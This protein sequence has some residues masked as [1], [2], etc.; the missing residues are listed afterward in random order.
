LSSYLYAGVAAQV[1]T[2]L[3]PYDQARS[4]GYADSALRAMEWAEAQPTEPR[5]ADLVVSHRSVAAAAMLKL[6]GDQR[7]HDA[8][9]EATTLDDGVDPNLSCHEHGR[10]DAAW[11]YLGIDESQT[12]PALR[13]TIEQSF[14][15]TAE[16]ILAAAAE[17]SFGWAVENPFV[18]LIWG[19]GVGGSPSSVGLLRAYELTGDER[20]RDGALRSAAVSLGANPLNTAFVTGVGANPVRHPL[21]VD[22]LNGG[23]PVWAGT[24]VYGN[25]RVNTLA[26]ES[27]VDEF[28]LG[29]A[30]VEPL[31]AELPYLWQW[32]DVSAVAMFNE[33]TVHQSHAEAVYA[34]GLLAAS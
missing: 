2:V 9:V 15:A 26:D 1:A 14:A 31:A 24:P 12:D 16:E 5:H 6:T 17:T 7:W 20:Y 33:Y 10:C 13:A 23:L 32:F 22:T 11:I 19:L 4:A 27:W 30:G 18:P 8:F 29:P 3:Q 34:Y 21:I 28:V 25:H